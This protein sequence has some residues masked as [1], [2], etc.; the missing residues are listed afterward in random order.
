M[1]P[2]KL[3]NLDDDVLISQLLREDGWVAQQ[4]MDGTFGR[5]VLRFGQE[6]MMTQNGVDPLK[7]T[8]ATQHL[9]GIWEALEPVR[10]L[11]SVEGDEFILE[12][13]I[14][15]KTGEYRLFEMVSARWD[16]M[17]NVTPESA[18]FH[19]NHSL[20]LVG[21]LAYYPVSVV[22][23]AT[24]PGARERLLTE[25][26]EA[27]VEGVVFKKV[28]HTYQFGVRSKDVLKYKFVKTADVVVTE[29]NRP[30]PKHG[31]FYF[32]VHHDGE[33]IPL[34][35][36]S[37]IGK[38]DAKVGDVIEVAYL[39]RD[40]TGGGLVQPRMTRIRE[41]KPAEECDTSQFQTYTREVV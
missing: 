20:T 7:H 14:M 37:A 40:P 35:S 17:Q 6:P 11:L 12:G 32:G 4:K 38:P 15:L 22:R 31:S 39:Y 25:C 36:C 21:R 30:D 3:T 16:G 23:T 2:M 28:S 29:V 5:A 34:G 8:A 9:E 41:D 27:G 1:K 18:W 10:A 26:R 24:S 19:R 33:F 13:E